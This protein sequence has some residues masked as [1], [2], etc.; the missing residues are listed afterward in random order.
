MKLWGVRIL[1]LTLVL[2]IG[3]LAWRFFFPG[4]ERVIRKRMDEIAKLASFQANEGP[5]ARVA[6]VQKLTSFFSG[7]VEVMLDVRGNQA[8]TFSGRAT[9]LQAAM[10]VRTALSSLT[11]EFLDVNVAVDPDKMSAVVHLTAKGKVPGDMQVQELK[12]IL[13]KIDGD[14]L[15]TRIET[16]KTLSSYERNSGARRFCNVGLTW[17]VAGSHALTET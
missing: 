5:L 1:L 14:W 16:V 15:I 2:G 17:P 11:V 8:Q 10:G 12:M 6:N 7:D 13:K 9:L 4:P 3:L